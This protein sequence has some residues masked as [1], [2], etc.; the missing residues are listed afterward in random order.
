MAI[1][2]TAV[3]VLTAMA[4]WKG[5]YFNFQFTKHQTLHGIMPYRKATSNMPAQNDSGQ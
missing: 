1:R 5:A 2:V 4:K 3:G